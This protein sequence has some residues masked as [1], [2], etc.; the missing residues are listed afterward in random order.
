M[1]GLKQRAL[2]SMLLLDANRVVS[3]DRL[4]DALWDE[5]PTATADK[6]LQGRTANA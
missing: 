2:L 6:A 1:G 5:Q 3:R 4:V